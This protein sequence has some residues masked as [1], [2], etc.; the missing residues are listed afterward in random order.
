MVRASRFEDWRGDV[1]S[2]VSRI[3]K[4]HLSWNGR[5][6]GTCNAM[7]RAPGAC[8]SLPSGERG[9]RRLARMDVIAAFHHCAD[10]SRIADDRILVLV[11]RRTV[12]CRRIRFYELRFVPAGGRFGSSRYETNAVSISAGPGRHRSWRSAVSLKRKRDSRQAGARMCGQHAQ[13]GSDHRRN[14]G[15]NFLGR[16]DRLG[17]G[18]PWFFRA[19]SG[20]GTRGDVRTLLS[21]GGDPAA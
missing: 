18:A 6:S 10:N 13:A 4:T 7:L 5:G 9:W 12:Q 17:F 19:K 1:R 16:R 2:T 15:A 14:A 21:P 3:C 8:P 11:A 20:R